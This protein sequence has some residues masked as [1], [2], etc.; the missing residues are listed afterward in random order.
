MKKKAYIK[1]KGLHAQQGLEGDDE[2]EVIYVGTCYSLNGKF[3]VKYMEEYDE[4]DNIETMLVI[5]EDEVE[6]VCRGM[7]DSHMVFIRGEKNL[8][9]YNT[10]FGKLNLGIDT[11]RLDVD[12]TQDG[13]VVD[14][15]YGIE[16]NM[17]SVSESHVH[18][19]VEVLK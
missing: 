10:P 17:G 18:I 2:I 19:E 9:C 6:I 15:D 1:I 4:D 14:I 5:S 8:N 3:Y 13:V 11:Y 16:I 7:R 12:I